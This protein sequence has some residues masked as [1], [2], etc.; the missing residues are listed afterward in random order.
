MNDVSVKERIREILIQ[1]ESNPTKLSKAFSV[2]QKTLNNQI[3]AD[4]QISLS[5][6]L[7][8]LEAFEDVS[9][10][11]LLRGKGAMLLSSDRGLQ[12]QQ[13]ENENNYLIDELKAELNQ[14]KGENRI[15]REMLNLKKS[16]NSERSKTA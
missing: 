1:K 15:L 16:E 4:V 14:L 10:E 5:T 3:N 7:L 12:P 8:I 9:A 13:S 2:N 11:W 6:I